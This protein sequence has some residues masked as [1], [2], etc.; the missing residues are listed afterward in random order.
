[1]RRVGVAPTFLSLKTDFSDSLS[2]NVDRVVL[3]VASD[4]RSVTEVC[5]AVVRFGKVAEARRVGDVS[6]D[7]AT[8]LVVQRITRKS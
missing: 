4:S 6:K 5:V 1:M 7:T 2:L 8:A 3:H